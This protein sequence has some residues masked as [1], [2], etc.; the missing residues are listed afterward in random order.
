MNIERFLAEKV[1]GYLFQDLEQLAQI[2]LPSGQSAGAAGYPM[3]LTTLSGMELLGALLSIKPYDPNNGD[4]H[5]AWYWTHFLSRSHELYRAPRNIP[6][7]VRGQARNP[8]AHV[9]ISGHGILVTK[10]RGKEHFY[11]DRSRRIFVIDCLRLFDDFVSSY[12]TLV[13]PILKGTARKIG[14]DIVITRDTMQDRLNEMAESSASA[15]TNLFDHLGPPKLDAAYLQTEAALIR[16]TITAS[17][18]F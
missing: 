15:A 8:M 13:V 18:G 3:V 14:D 2:T 1:E 7:L 4:S 5:F 9:F 12:R 6:K 11:L 17:R 10:S 16:S